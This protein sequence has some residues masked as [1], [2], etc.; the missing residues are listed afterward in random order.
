[1]CLA[2]DWLKGQATWSDWYTPPGAHR[3]SDDICL[4]Q[5][6]NFIL[7][8]GPLGNWQRVWFFVYGISH[9]VNSTQ[10]VISLLHPLF[11]STKQ[12]WKRLYQHIEFMLL[13]QHGR[14]VMVLGISGSRSIFII[15]LWK[16]IPQFL[17]CFPIIKDILFTQ[18][19][20]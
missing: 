18:G 16:S 8:P 2:S 5:L 4:M 9:S 12:G 10:R 19:H 17:Y 15:P 20:R 7:H 6:F 1:M 11:P 13:I 3:L 14:T